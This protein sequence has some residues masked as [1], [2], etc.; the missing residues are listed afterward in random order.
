MK[1]ANASPVT[2]QEELAPPQPKSPLRRIVLKVCVV[3][4]ALALVFAPPPSP[5]REAPGNQSWKSNFLAI[6][7]S[8]SLS[9]TTPRKGCGESRVSEMRY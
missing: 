8:V 3:I 7:R 4:L 2:G 6:M 1:Q 9:F 5:A